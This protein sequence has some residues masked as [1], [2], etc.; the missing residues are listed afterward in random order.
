MKFQVCEGTYINELSSCSSAHF[1]E[2]ELNLVPISLKFSYR[3]TEL[4]EL[5]SSSSTDFI[6]LVN[7]YDF[8][9]ILGTDFSSENDQLTGYNR[10]SL[11][12]SRLLTPGN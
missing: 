10:L 9:Q 1:L 2:L 8:D 11:K 6:R 5:S 4:D 7:D 12:C 3:G